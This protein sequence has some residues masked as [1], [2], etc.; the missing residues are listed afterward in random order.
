MKLAER[1]DCTGCGA[2][3]AAC[4]KG[5][6]S[7]E[8]DFEGFPQPV[9]DEEKCI[10]CGLCEKVCPA[11]NKPGERKA[12]DVYAAQIKDR[13]AL[14]QST[15]GGLF[16]LFSR[17]IL[18]RGGVVYGCVWDKDYNAVFTKAET[19]EELAPMRGSKYVWCNAGICF[20][21]IKDFLSAGR[22]VLFTGCPCQIA[23]LRT[24]L[25]KDYEKLYLISFFCGGAPSPMAFH[26]YIETITKD[27]PKEK[28]DFKLRDKSK[29]GVGVNISY[30][31]KH[32]RV[33]EDYLQNPY[34]FCYHTKLFHR[35]P[36]YHCSYRYEARY[37][38]ITFGDY[39]GIKKYH[40]EFDIRAGVS[41]MLV[42]SEK[43]RELLD[44]VKD[45]V[46]LVPT[47]I[48]HI[49]DGNN[50]T[51]G[52]KIKTFPVPKFR[53]DFLRIVKEKGWDSADKKYLH[54][55][56]RTKLRVKRFLKKKIFSRLPVGLQLKIKKL[57][58]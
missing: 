30:N 27:V 4:P 17:E 57:L 7:Y 43:G 10:N 5:A 6:I 14:A 40:T 52:D 16:T 8:D 3:V 56:V 11:L 39:W 54:G 55:K 23:A 58:H 13:E 20:K 50:L 12:L 1:S 15:S 51:L 36:C 32:G 49:A 42:N 26:A 22:A 33:H 37:D 24:F 38:D 21:E 44:S 47:K 48:E 2:C 31:G 34:F 9:V 53:E 35:P 46:Q 19:E 18:K 25:R 45:Q 41:A 28:L 29:Y